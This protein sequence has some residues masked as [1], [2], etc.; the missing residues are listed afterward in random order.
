MCET[1]NALNLLIEPIALWVVTGRW[2]R[3]ISAHPVDG[4]T[5]YKLGMNCL[6][7][8]MCCSC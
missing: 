6:L 4:H 2:M 3:S 5:V 7:F 1:N 8:T